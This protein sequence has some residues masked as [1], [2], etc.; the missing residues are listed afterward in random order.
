MTDYNDVSNV[1]SRALKD[2]E[3]EKTLGD[4]E[5]SVN[6]ALAQET[7]TGPEAKANYA[8]RRSHLWK[9]QCNKHSDSL[10]TRRKQQ[11][12]LIDSYDEKTIDKKLN[13]AIESRKGLYKDVF[14]KWLNQDPA[15]QGLYN[16]LCKDKI[17]QD[18]IKKWL[19]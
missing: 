5:E 2:L 3:Y 13:E 18:F 17:N 15:N 1:R 6:I 19:S 14:N 12:D 9:D 10:E 8:E 7:F 11:Y 4:I 16:E